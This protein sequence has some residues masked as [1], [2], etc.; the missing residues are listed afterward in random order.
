MFDSGIFY[1]HVSTDSNILPE[2]ERKYF[3]KTLAGST[4]ITCDFACYIV[5]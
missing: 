2:H 1:F 3:S 5:T 4:I